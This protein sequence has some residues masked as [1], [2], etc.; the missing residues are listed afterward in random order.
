MLW[1]PNPSFCV[2]SCFVAA[3]SPGNHSMQ[4]GHPGSSQPVTGRT[5]A[6]KSSGR[7]CPVLGC[8]HP[9]SLWG[10]AETQLQL[11]PHLHLSSSPPSPTSLLPPGLLGEHTWQ[12]TGT[13][14]PISAHSFCSSGARAQTVGAGAGWPRSGQW[15]AGRKPGL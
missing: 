8:V 3:S 14:L 2:P 6:C 13:S 9:S 10:Q 7:T 4:R 12:I 5:Q 1:G 11:K 15:A